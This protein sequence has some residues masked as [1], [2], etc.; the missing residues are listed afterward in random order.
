MIKRHFSL[1]TAAILSAGSLTIF[2]ADLRI[3]M[4]GL[5]TSHCVEFTK[6]LNDPNDK[7]HIEG[8][9]VVAAFKGGSPDIKESWDRIEGYTKKLQENYGVKIVGSIEEL[10][11]EVDVVMLESLDGRPH[12]EQAKPVITAKKPLFVD[13][14]VAGSLRDAIELFRMAKENNVPIYS[15]SSLRFYPSLQDLKKANFGE[16]RS[17]ISTGPGSIEPHHPDLF[18]YG[19]HATEALYT[20]TGPGCESVVCSITPDTHTVT[21]IWKDGKTGTVRAARN[22][23]YGFQMNVFGSKANLNEK[24]SGDYTPFL[25]EVMKFFQTGI[26]PVSPEETLEIY[27]FM[28]AADESTRQGGCPVKIADVMKKAGAK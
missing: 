24:I 8:G 12:L 11:K 26:A 23:A 27:A 5:D 16:L 1:F 6:R 19:I 14:P 4:I 17:A 7:N 9:K 18:W 3:G 22:A 20:L 10:C 28:E 21:G 2:A 13:K 15:G 25:L